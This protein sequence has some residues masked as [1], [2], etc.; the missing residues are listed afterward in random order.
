VERQ[1]PP[2]VLHHLEQIRTCVLNRN[3]INLA[4]LN[5][6]MWRTCRPVR[7]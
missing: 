3:P 2:R 4:H 7:S 5:G 6:V 1:V